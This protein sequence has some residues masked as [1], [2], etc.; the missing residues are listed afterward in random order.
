MLPALNKRLGTNNLNLNQLGYEAARQGMTLS[1]VIAM[2]EQDD[3]TYNGKKQM[4]CST[5]VASIWK[6]A[7]LFNN[8]DIN[9]S[10]FTPFDLYR[11]NLF[12]SKDL[13]PTTC[14]RDDPGQQWC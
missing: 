9:A 1:E 3:W 12:E 8:L 10:E 6:A 13:R 4:V 2:P 11:V 5:F 14:Q 7:G